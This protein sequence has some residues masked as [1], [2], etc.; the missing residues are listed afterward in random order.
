MRRTRPSSAFRTLAKV[1]LLVCLAGVSAS[2]CDTG[3]K[4]ATSQPNPDAKNLEPGTQGSGATTTTAPVATAPPCRA[5]DLVARGGRRQDPSGAGGAV[6]DVMI[7]SSA[8]VACE[9]KGIPSLQIVRT[10][11]SLLKIQNAK[12]NTPA[13]APVVV[14]PKGKSTAEL[15]FTWQNWCEPSPGTLLML[16]GLSSGGGTLTAPLNGKLGSYV[17][18]CGRPDAPSVL[19]VEYAYVPAGTANLASA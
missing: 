8:A 1:G 16:V 13:L 15:V 5:K 2:A 19:R 6:G 4:F 18:T 10:N 3:Y 11:G 12:A 14:E 17:P 7:S 9:L